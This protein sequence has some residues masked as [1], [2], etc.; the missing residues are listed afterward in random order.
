MPEIYLVKAEKL[1]VYDNSDQSIQIVV[2]TNPLESSYEQAEA[3]IKELEV[4]L[5]N[6]SED[7]K[8]NFSKL[9]GELVFDSNFLKDDYLNAVDSVKKYIK[10]GD[11]MQVVLAQDFSLPFNKNPF[12]LYK[13]L[14]ALNP[15]PYMY[16]LDL[17]ECQVVGASPEIL[18]RLEENKVTLRP[19]AGTRKRG[20]N[21]AED[22]ALSLIH[23]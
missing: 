23:I 4:L 20:T 3:T 12:D 18:I 7:S 16:Y 2:N 17:E 13:A 14:R 10:E 22:L 9:T 5:S 8:D 15:S 19:I 6:D 1:I 21:P 11:V